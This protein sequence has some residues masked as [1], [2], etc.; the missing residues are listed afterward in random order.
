MPASASSV[1]HPTGAIGRFKI[2]RLLGKG[3]QSEVYLAHDPHLDREV[4]IKTLHFASSAERAA[5][6]DSL[7]TEARTVSRLQH[8]NIVTLYDAGEHE[9]QPYLVF[10]LVDGPTLA[11]VLKEEGPVSAPRAAELAI[12]ILDAIGYAHAQ[13]IIHRDLKP[14]NVLLGANGVARVMDFGVAGRIDNQGAKSGYLMGTPAYMAPEY[15]ANEDFGPQSDLFSFGMLMYELLTGRHAVRGKDVHDVMRRIVTDPIAAPSQHN[16]EIDEKLDDLLLKAL[17]KDPAERFDGAWLM[18]NAFE[19]YLSPDVPVRPRT[20]NDAKQS[21]LDFLLRR[22]R[23][24]SDFPALSE[25]VTAINRIAASDKES[26]NQLSNTILKDFAL[27]NKLLR[28]VNAAFYGHIGGGS[29]STISR[30]VVILGFDAVRSIAVTL[31]LFDNLQNKGHAQQ[32]K[33]EFI[34]VLYAGMLARGMAG[35]AQVKDAEEAFI[36][37][38]FHN[39]GRM[40]SMFYFLEETEEIKKLI[41]TKGFSDVK[42]STQVL[43][44]SFEDLG[45]GIAKSWGFP[46]QIVLSMR[47]LPD[48]KVKKS[49][50]N[51]DKLRVLAGFSNELCE[52]IVG[53]PEADRAKALAK[54]TARFGDSLAL[55]EKQLSALMEKSMQD[56]AQFASAVNVNLKQS[57]FAQQASK[58]AGVSE[59][60]PAPPPLAEISTAADGDDA[61]IQTALAATVLHEHAPVL[62]LALSADGSKPVP[63]TEEIQTILTSGLKDISNSLID[64]N[65]SVNDILRMILE[66][67]YSGMGFS[68]V[69]FCIKDSRQNAMCGKFGFGEGVQALLKAFHFSMVEQP[70]VFHVALKNNADILITDIDDAKIATRIPHWYRQHVSARTFVIF[71]ITVKGKSIGL[72][73][74]DRAQPGEIV[75][76]E[77]ELSL[78]KA[79]RNQAVLAIRQTL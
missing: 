47:K 5:N 36:C 18:K 52:V 30:A 78:L 10:E 42:A 33:E 22:M 51:T 4:A 69:V 75:I 35:K 68:H 65:I 61:D 60:P 48:E 59:A 1:I 67:M 66:A 79:L 54:L 27:T 55:T 34:K 20:G 45:I 25:A 74:A 16:A 62:D 77:K 26:V 11:Q 73:Y 41:Q 38:M 23:L 46:D 8:P 14:S 39:L 58:W 7:L 31:M 19:L 49:A 70:D 37:S 71:P 56:I 13:G 76:P 43:G 21:T 57:Q 44:L 2:L 3:N 15:I 6:V 24:K 29:I 50:N 17:K 32:L 40:L 12:Q 53:T 63:T 9:G 64:D 28:L 72:I